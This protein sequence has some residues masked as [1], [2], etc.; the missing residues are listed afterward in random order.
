MRGSRS[1][2]D[3]GNHQSHR[4]CGLKFQLPKG[5]D[6]EVWSSFYLESKVMEAPDDLQNTCQNG[7][8]KTSQDCMR[9][10]DNVRKQST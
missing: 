9:M 2:G 7:S 1:P 4:K 10:R 8:K 5:V 6:S 3:R